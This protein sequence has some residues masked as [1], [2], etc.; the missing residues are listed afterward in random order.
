VLQSGVA[1]GQ[2]GAKLHP[3]G[4][5]SSEGVVPGICRSAVPGRAVAGRLSISPRV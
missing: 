2:R 4:S 5:D 1:S 3:G